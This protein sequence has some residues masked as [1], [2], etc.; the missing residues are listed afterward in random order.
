MI[1]AAQAAGGV[2][3]ALVMLRAA[4][5]L[6]DAWRRVSFEQ[7]RRRASLDLLRERV[8]LAMAQKTAARDT[9][10]RFWTGYRKFEVERKVKETDDIASFYLV[11]HNRK[12]L[13]PFRPGQYLTFRFQLAGRDKPLIRCYSLSDAADHDRYRITIKCIPSPRD[14][15]EVPPGLASS[16]L[17]DVVTTG[18][19]LDV[20]APSGNFY[21]DES[22]D[23]PVVLI[24]GGI[25]LTPLLSM[26]NAIVATPRTRE[27]WLF[28]GVRDSSEEAMGDHLRDMAE[29]HAHV[30]LIR[31]HS[32]PGDGETKGEDYDYAQRIDLKLLREI[33]PSSN[34]DFYICAPSAMM[35]DM[36][37]GLRDWGVP[38][39]RIHYEAFGAASVQK[40]VTAPET[41]ADK[42]TRIAVTF[43][44]SG[45]TV[46]WTPAVGT[47]LDLAEGN[48]VAIDYGCRAGNCGTCLIAVRSGEVTYLSRPGAAAESGTCLA[49]IGVPKSPLTLDA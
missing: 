37:Q 16:H 42:D 1:S 46:E 4:L 44:R 11:P 12:P 10:E 35:H 8:E 24:A 25:G 32:R 34:F 14:K 17:H 45:K 29:E 13:P 9:A 38:E 3:V 31:V 18:H 15:P 22:N 49:C 27:T 36:Y 41:A 2:L 26:L 19:L 21:L 39:E 6:V 28:Y 47:I 43:A 33:L 48:D 23:R 30:H 5:A 20:M 7:D 40:V